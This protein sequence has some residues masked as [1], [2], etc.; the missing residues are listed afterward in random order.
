MFTS[1][2]SDFIDRYTLN[3]RHSVSCFMLCRIRTQSAVWYSDAIDQCVCSFPHYTLTDFR[4]FL[5]L[6][7]F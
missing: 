5:Q 2:E 7:R 3:I 1:P 4:N 6:Q